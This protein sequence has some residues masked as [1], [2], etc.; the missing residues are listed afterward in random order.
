MK[1]AELMTSEVYC[2]GPGDGLNVPARAMWELDCG[3]V[4]VV[5]EERRLVGMITDRDV[6]MAAY[7][8]GRPLSEIAVD[9][10]MARVVHTCS[11]KD[12][13]TTAE[14][15][16]AESQVR[17]LPVVDTDGT[18]MGILSMRDIARRSP[19]LNASRLGRLV[20]EL[21]RP[22]TQGQSETGK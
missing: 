5:D 6:C 13:L 14:K 22:P 17:R 18:L 8:Q 3:C 9:S 7:T 10:A 21:S 12:A 20:V 16:M 15:I 11:P 1:V 4:P 19:K 2:C